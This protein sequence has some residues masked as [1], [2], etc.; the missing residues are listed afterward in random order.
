MWSLM[1]I[2]TDKA[3]F[4]KFVFKREHLT[5][6]CSMDHFCHF[7]FP[8]QDGVSLRSSVKAGEPWDSDG[9]HKRPQTTQGEVQWAQTNMPVGEFC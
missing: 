4:V 3:L 9:E 7:T 2:D 8:L 6:I 1:Y 5:G